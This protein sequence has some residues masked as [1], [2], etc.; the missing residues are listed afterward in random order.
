MQAQDMLET[1]CKTVL[2]K[3]TP[4]PEE[5]RK[6]EDLARRLEKSVTEAAERF[7]VK[8]T[9]RLEGSVA[10]DTWLS[11]EPDIDIFMRLPR[12]IPRS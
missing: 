2:E 9:V 7:G 4:K 6:I 8:A 12:S 1:V 5:R 10:K 11:G 3:I